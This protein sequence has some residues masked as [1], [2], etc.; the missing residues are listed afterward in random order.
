M[1]MSMTEM[2]E[3]IKANRKG[4]EIKSVRKCRHVNNTNMATISAVRSQTR[5]VATLSAH[6][7]TAD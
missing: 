6:P 3:T 1:R 5:K 4:R 7:V 2:A